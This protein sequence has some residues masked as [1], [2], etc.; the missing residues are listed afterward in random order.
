MLKAELRVT[1]FNEYLSVKILITKIISNTF[2][3]LILRSIN[4]VSFEY[5]TKLLS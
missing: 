4:L 5:K 2:K 1:C 3:Y